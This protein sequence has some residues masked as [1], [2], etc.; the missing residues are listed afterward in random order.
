[1]GTES[2]PKQAKLFP[3]KGKHWNYFPPTIC[4]QGLN[5]GL[6]QVPLP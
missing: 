6:A 3:L 5:E 1:M 4:M 2:K